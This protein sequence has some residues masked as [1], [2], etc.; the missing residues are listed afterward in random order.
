[1][2]T[3]K[4]NFVE[5]D[6]HC[7][8]GIVSWISLSGLSLLVYRN[9]RDFCALILYPATL[10][11]SLISTS[12]F[13][14]ASLVFCIYSIMPSANSD[15]FTPSFPI[16]IHFISISSLIAMAR[17]S[18]TML[19]KSGGSGHPCLVPDL[20][21]NAFSFPPLS[22]MLAVSLSY[23]A[24]IMVSYGW[25]DWC[26]PTGGWSWVLFLWWAGPSQGVCLESA[27]G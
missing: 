9:V 24:F 22:M 16:W 12:S 21:G 15:G 3:T 6:W 2:V 4:W 18:K 7:L 26:L 27:L 8:N 5:W 10:P 23:M 19:S 25:R 13:L 20:R 17:A 1:M 11:N 14:V